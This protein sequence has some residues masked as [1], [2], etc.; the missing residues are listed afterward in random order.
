MI[1][2]NRTT[3]RDKSVETLSFIKGYFGVCYSIITASHKKL[4]PPP[5]PPNNVG[6]PIAQT[7]GFVAVQH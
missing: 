5:F 4:P 3:M 7:M 1:E 6:F 2:G